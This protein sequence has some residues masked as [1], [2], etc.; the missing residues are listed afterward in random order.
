MSGSICSN[1]GI[2]LTEVIVAI[3]VASVGIVSL[4]AVQPQSWNLAGRSDSL[5]RAAGI[6]QSEMSLNEATIMNPDL[7]IPQD[8][9]RT[10]YVSRQGS[11]QSGDAMYTVNT[12][13][14]AVGTTAWRVRVTVSWPSNAAGISDS[15]IV[16]RQEGYRVSS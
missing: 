16:T 4:L 9:V 3:L 13:V 2:S 12:Q 6:L 11:K 1:R 14:E 15:I 7:A 5:G 8:Q 10:I